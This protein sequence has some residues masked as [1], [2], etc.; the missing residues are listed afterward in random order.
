MRITERL[1]LELNVKGLIN[2][3][4]AYRNDTLY[5]LEVN[6]RA[7][8]TVP[9][10]SKTTNVPLA[11]LAAKIATGATLKEMDLPPW[12]THRHIAVKE[13]VLPFNKFPEE[14]LF[15]GPEMKSTGEVMGISRGLGDSYGRASISAGN[16]LPDGGT[17]FLSVNEHDKLNAIPIAR[18]LFELGFTIVATSGT[19]RELVR[20]GIDASPVF[21]VG[22][23]RPN[24][25]DGI[26]NGEIHL[27][28]NTPLGKQSRYDEE[29]IGQAC[30]KKGVNAITTLS[31]AQAAIRAMRNKRPIE[32]RALQDYH[33]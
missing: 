6:P 5:V 3:Q 33:G 17:V 16:N 15:L 19:A 32:V 10:V 1:A 23:G 21:K 28:I 14:S 13:A 27:V 18:D 31:G 4:F 20:N 2:L 12:D 8:R 9:F 11:R 25:V 22:E 29:A 7:S 30:I 24:V 26:K